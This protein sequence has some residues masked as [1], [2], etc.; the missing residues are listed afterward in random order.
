MVFSHFLLAAFAASASAAPVIKSWFGPSQ[1]ATLAGKLYFGTAINIPGPSGELEDSEYMTM[2][3]NSNM[4]G[5]ATPANIMKV[6]DL[7]RGKCS[8][9]LSLW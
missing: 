4:F 2:F 3:N 5:Q 8:F 1:Y 7:H 9:M 6:R